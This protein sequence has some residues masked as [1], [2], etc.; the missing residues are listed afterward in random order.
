MT[1]QSFE[2]LRPAR[3]PLSRFLRALPVVGRVIREIEREIDTI[4]YL[5]VI[6]LTALVLAVQ[7]WGLAALVVTAVSLV[8]VIFVLLIWITLP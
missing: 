2:T 7:A 1:A 5:I 4:Y 6:L 3:S 8:P